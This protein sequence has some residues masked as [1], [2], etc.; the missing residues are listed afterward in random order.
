MSGDFFRYL[1][2]NN[3]MSA[4]KKYNLIPES[5]DSGFRPQIC[6]QENILCTTLFISCTTNFFIGKGFNCEQLFQW[7][8]SL[9]DRMSAQ[10]FIWDQQYFVQENIY[11]FLNI[12]SKQNVSYFLGNKFE[13][14]KIMS[15]ATF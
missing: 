11:W 13:R 2:Q 10:H 3:K 14:R 9:N 4:V 8:F 5:N 12:S 6:L 7:Y 1:T 15:S